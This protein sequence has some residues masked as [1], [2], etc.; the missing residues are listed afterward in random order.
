[1]ATLQ[2]HLF[3]VGGADLGDQM[4]GGVIGH[5]VVV[6]GDRVQDRH[7]D[8]SEIGGAAAD[9]HGVVVKLVVPHQVFGDGAEIFAGQR[10]DVVG[11][12]VKHS[13]RIDV[14]V[15]PDVVPQLYLTR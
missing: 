7:P 14:F 3:L 6:F 11:P 5:D 4:P 12:A 13:I 10:Q 9:G 1:M 8:V 2:H 15:I